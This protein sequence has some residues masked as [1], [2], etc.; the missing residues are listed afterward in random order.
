MLVLC[1]AV[2]LSDPDVIVAPEVLPAQTILRTQ[3]GESANPYALSKPVIQVI[4]FGF[5]QA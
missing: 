4:G 3:Q 2:S 1:Y 5:L